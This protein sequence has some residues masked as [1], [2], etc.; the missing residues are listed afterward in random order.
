M[1]DSTTD[2]LR[3]HIYVDG[4]TDAVTSADGRLFEGE[5]LV[6]LFPGTADEIG[7]AVVATAEVLNPAVVGKGEVLGTDVEATAGVGT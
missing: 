4:E 1:F 5:I 7:T 6:V 2:G 3:S